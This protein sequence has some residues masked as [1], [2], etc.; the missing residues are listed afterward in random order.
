MLQKGFLEQKGNTRRMDRQKYLKAGG[1]V[2]FIVG[3]L[4]TM[5]Q[6]KFTNVCLVLV[7]VGSVMVS[8][9][10]WMDVFVKYKTRQNQKISNL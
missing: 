2:F 6:D 1:A 5:Q 4:M 7:I 9:G 10:L 8:V 3:A